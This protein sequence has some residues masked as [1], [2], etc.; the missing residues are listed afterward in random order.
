MGSR[1]RLNEGM[2]YGCCILTSLYDQNAD[3]NLK[4]EYNCFISKSP[5]EYVDRIEKLIKDPSSKNLIKKNA[6]KTY[7]TKF[8]KSVACYEYEKDILSLVNNE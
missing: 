5:K 2:A 7:N 3:P 1:S 6:L 4:D 8:K